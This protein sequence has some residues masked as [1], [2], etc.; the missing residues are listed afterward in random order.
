MKID[1]SRRALV[2]AFWSGFLGDSPSW[3]KVFVVIAVVLNTTLR[4][5]VGAHVV[6]WAV[7]VEFICCLA[8]SLQCYPLVSGGMC[9]CVEQ[10]C[11]SLLKT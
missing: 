4:Y 9:V 2:G 10:L 6:A 8:F 11:S 5:A 1:L 7:L 3:V